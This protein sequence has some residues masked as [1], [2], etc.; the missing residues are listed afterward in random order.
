M[1]PSFSWKHT[2]TGNQLK[3]IACISMVLDHFAKVF[4]TQLNPV[5]YF[6][7]DSILGRIAFPVFCFLLAEG[8][9]HTRNLRR[10]MIR[11]LLLALVSEIPFNLAMSGNLYD[12][13]WQNTI[14][15][16][17]F[18][19]CMYAVLDLIRGKG[20][21]DHRISILLQILTLAFFALAAWVL[22][23]DYN[24]TGIGALACFYYLN[25]RICSRPVLADAWACVCLFQ[26]PAAFLSLLP[27]S[28]YS[29]TRG[30]STMK[31]FFYIFYPAHLTLLVLL[32][33]LLF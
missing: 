2:L 16:L 10:Y 11:M 17:L 4:H 32:H 28:A 15:T 3:G 22:R 30:K 29:H 26:E 12:P 20:M 1:H 31:Y 9:F 7:L 19:L 18:G 8:Y 23:L 33:K 25:G 13:G 24:F 5:L 6:V 27:V 14:F 21:I